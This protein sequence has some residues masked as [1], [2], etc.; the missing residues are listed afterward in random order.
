MD[1]EWLICKIMA[2]VVTTGL[3]MNY[4]ENNSHMLKASIRICKVYEYFSRPPLQDTFDFMSLTFTRGPIEVN[5]HG[6]H[7]SCDMLR[8]FLENKL[9]PK[10]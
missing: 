9:Q 4:M 6:L 7:I 1:I 8:V 2:I 5:G 10:F 3:L